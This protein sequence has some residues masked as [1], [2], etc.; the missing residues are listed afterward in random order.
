MAALP[1]TMRALAAPKSCLP[2][3]YELIDFPVPEIKS[4]NEVLIRVHA[5]SLITGDT[6]IARNASK[7]LGHPLEYPFIPG[8]QGSGIVEQVGTGVSNIRPGDA[9]YGASSKHPFLPYHYPALAAEYAVM[10]A[11]GLILKPPQ[12]SFE[13]AASLPG[14]TVT[15]LQC[16]R[17]G[18]EMMGLD[19]LQG[20]TVIVPAA[21]GGA[22]SVGCQVAKRV[23]GAEKVITS[24]STAKMPMVEKHLGL[25]I[26][27]Q[28]VDYTK[29][30]LNEIEDGVADLVYATQWSAP[31]YFRKVDSEKGV[32][33][34]I[35]TVPPSR[36]LRQTVGKENIPF[37]LAWIVDAIQLWYAWLLRGTR[38]RMEFVSGNLGVREDL[39]T[40]GEWVATG[41]IKPVT[42]VVDLCDIETVR[43]EMMKVSSGHGGVGSLVLKIV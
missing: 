26:I 40:I 41:K 8:L 23:Y 2:S 42:T 30:G 11:E 15:A 9:V 5:A 25:G 22:G 19:S 38:R 32:I 33:V 16:F 20:K 34:S 18:L 39:E 13:D 12:V 7:W 43:R 10:P 27:D 28:A 17:K 35:A 3:E 29:G 6:Q 14:Y 37:W 1:T 21:L 36:L 4:P 24:L 31:E